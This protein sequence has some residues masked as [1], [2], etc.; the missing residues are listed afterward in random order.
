[1][2]TGN[3]LS[4]LLITTDGRLILLA[5]RTFEILGFEEQQ[6]KILYRVRI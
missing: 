2:K 1:M 6:G 4:N 5:E 3:E